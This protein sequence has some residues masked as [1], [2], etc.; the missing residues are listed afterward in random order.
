MEVTVLPII[1]GI[2]GTVTK[3]LVKELEDLKMRTNGDHRN[4]RIIKIGQHTE[5]SPGN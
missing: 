2:L 5:K 3:G 4:Y 1:I